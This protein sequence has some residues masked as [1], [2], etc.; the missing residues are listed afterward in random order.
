MKKILLIILL[1]FSF[2]S[3]HALEIPK[4]ERV[5]YWVKE[6]SQNRRIFFQKSIIRSGLYRKTVKEIFEL[7]G[8][9]EDLSWL[10]FIESGFNCSADSKAGAAGCWQ[11][12]KRTGEAFGLK[13]GTWKDQRY[14]FN[15]STRAAAQYLSKLY[16]RF[17]NWDLALAAYNGGPTTVV[18]AIKKKKSKNYWDLHLA[19]E[20]MDYHPQFY[21]VL[22]I[23]RDLSKYGF[24]KSSNSL[25]SVQ[26]KE[27]SHSLRYIASG[28]LRVDYKDFLRINPGYELG[29]TPPGEETVIYLMDEWDDTMLRA[30]GLLA[31]KK[32]LRIN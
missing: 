9:P 13:K 24:N 30:F 12:M 28:I 26:L 8:L 25:K 20:T 3:I 18:A 19:S 17:R 22:K 15:R 29:Y 5:D 10:P 11:F 23:T 6:F 32:P 21:A 1:A 16:K 4:N 7:E 27:G 2:S 14:D 31:Q